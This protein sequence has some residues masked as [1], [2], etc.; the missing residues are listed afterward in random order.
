MVV[1]KSG[2]MRGLEDN[3]TKFV[4]RWID[5]ARKLSNQYDQK[6]FISI[7]EYNYFASVIVQN[8]D[9]EFYNGSYKYG[10]PNSG[11][12][13]F[14]AQ[15]DAINLVDKFDLDEDRIQKS[16]L[17]NHI[18]DGYENSS[19]RHN[20]QKVISNMVQRQSKNNWTFTFLLPPGNK[21]SF[22]RTYGLEAGNI[23]EWETT[24]AGLYEAEEKTSS[25]LFQY[26]AARS[27]G[28]SAVKNFYDV[29][30]LV[31]GT[32]IIVPRY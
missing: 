31:R 28:S 2:S 16:F 32:E 13:L 14:D 20:I 11:T 12:A 30:K 17:I 29:R 7:V 19:I 6:T 27:V 4:N 15:Q 24:K 3:V 22:V 25:G 5:D 9:I 23:T 21:N 10:Y 8:T 26:Y 1:D 18:T